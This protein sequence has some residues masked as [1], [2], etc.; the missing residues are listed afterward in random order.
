MLITKEMRPSAHLV[1]MVMRAYQQYV[2]HVLLVILE[3]KPVHLVMKTMTVQKLF[4]VPVIVA[5]KVLMNVHL[6]L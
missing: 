1:M 3:H 5:I 6:V 2:L 4:A